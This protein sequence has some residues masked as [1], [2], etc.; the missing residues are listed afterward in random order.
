MTDPNINALIANG[1]TAPM[2]TLEGMNT[3]GRVTS[4]YDG[5]TLTLAI[6]LFG[7]VYRFSM[8]VNGIDTPEIKSKLVE[9]KLQ[10]VRARNRLL[11]LIG[12]RIELEDEWKKKDIDAALAA[13]PFIIWVECSESDKYGRILCSLYKDP[14]KTESFANVLIRENFAYAYGGGAKMTED[15]QVLNRL[16]S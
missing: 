11:Q 12:V 14:M 4:V 2:F 16:V 3:W 7:G 8:R 5:D 15:N 9:N 1:T 10:A 13:Q 6:P